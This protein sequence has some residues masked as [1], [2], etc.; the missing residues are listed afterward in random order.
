MQPLEGD[1]KE[2]IKGKEIKILTPNRLLSRLPI[3]F[4]QI[5]AGNNSCKLKKRNQTN[6]TFF[7]STQ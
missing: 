5:K 4:A 6:T 3:L 1:E 2:E 7:V